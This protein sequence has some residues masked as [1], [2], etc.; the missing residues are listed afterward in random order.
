MSWHKVCLVCLDYN[1][2]PK[3]SGMDMSVYL[4]LAKW[5]FLYVLTIICGACHVYLSIL[6]LASVCL[7]LNYVVSIIGVGYVV[8]HWQVCLQQLA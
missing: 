4:S 5:Y 6:S 1:H 3:V 2:M 7:V 8:Y